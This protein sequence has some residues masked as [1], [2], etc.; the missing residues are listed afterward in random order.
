[1]LTN[2]FCTSMGHTSHRACR[3]LAYI[4]VRGELLSILYRVRGGDSFDTAPGR[5]SLSCASRQFLVPPSRHGSGNRKRTNERK[6]R[7][8]YLSSYYVWRVIMQCA[9]Q[10]KRFGPGHGAKKRYGGRVALSCVPG[11]KIATEMQPCKSDTLRSGVKQDCCRQLVGILTRLQ[12]IFTDIIR[13]T[14]AGNC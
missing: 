2:T 13:A 11:Q 8:H 6:I 10:A 5:K 4:L 7:Y 9:I 12:T 14:L 3:N 1:M